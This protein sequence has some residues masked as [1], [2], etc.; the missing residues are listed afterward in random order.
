MQQGLQQGRGTLDGTVELEGGLEHSWESGGPGKWE[1]PPEMK[2]T[3]SGRIGE[4]YEV[5]RVLGGEGKSG[6]GVV[7]VCYDHNA[8]QLYALKTFQDKYIYSDRVKDSFKREALAWVLLDGHPNIVQAVCVE[9]LDD[10][11][12]II[13]EYIEP[14]DRK[15]NTMAHYLEEPISLLQ[16]LEWAM[17]F[18]DGM[19]YAASQGVT[20]HRD[21]KPDNIMIARDGTLKVTDFG[22][23]KLWE[24]AWLAAESDGYPARSM[25]GT[26]P[27][28]APEQFEGKS[29]L[30]SDIYSFGIVLYQMASGGTLPFTSDSLEGYH[31]LH[32]S[33]PAPKLRSKLSPIINKCLRKSPDER[34]A[35]FRSLRADLE[36]LY[37][38]QTDAEPPAIPEKTDPGLWEYNNR[39]LALFNV[40]LVD[41]AIWVYRKALRYDQAFAEQ[42]KARMAIVHNNLGVAYDY[43][44]QPDLAV[45][46]YREAI[47]LRPDLAD[48]HNNLGTALRARGK[49][50]DAVREYRKALS[51]KPGYAIARH[52]LGLSFACKG[53]LDGAIKEYGEAI[54]LKP[55]FVEARINLGLAHAMKGRLDRAISEYR[56]A[57]RLRPDA[58]IIHFNLA[59]TLK[60]KGDNDDAIVEYRAALQLEPD[61]A[62]AR[63]NLGLLLE[64]KGLLQDAITGYMGVLRMEPGHPA[65]M[66]NLERALRRSGTS[67]AA[68]S[69][70]LRLMNEEKTDG[71]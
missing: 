44:G 3:V 2:I 67:E 31:L 62:E 71:R 33:A 29:D 48:A 50:D 57:A 65:A 17:Q 39:G 9:Y 60:A 64:D 10:R 36:K 41:E 15:R 25:A 13:L 32:K 12:Y 26:A 42:H 34:Y 4:Q 56:K 70:C 37:G 61:H 16:A 14:D 21:I 6:M 40:G 49:T 20:P 63:L 27:W 28:M 54:R 8:G 47:R 11:L 51:L 7:Y 58:A 68:L 59:N 5:R 1:I 22:L 69:A 23:A 19:A 30:R 52:N 24:G 35:D 18:C 38:S 53:D 45:E 46:E 66:A 55:G 43:R